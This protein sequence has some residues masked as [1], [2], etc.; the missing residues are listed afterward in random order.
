MKV[1]VTGAAGS[2]GARLCRRLAECGVSVLA[3][4]KDRVDRLRRADSFIDDF[5]EAATRDYLD[6]L[7]VLLTEGWF[8]PRTDREKLFFVIVSR[9]RKEKAT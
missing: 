9:R 5:G 8:E 1:I 4:D 3:L 6:R 7:E 2:I